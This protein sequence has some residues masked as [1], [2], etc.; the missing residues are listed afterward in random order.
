MFVFASF[1]E[2]LLTRGMLQRY[3]NAEKTSSNRIF[4]GYTFTNTPKT[5]SFRFRRFLVFSVQPLW[6]MMFPFLFF[7][8]IKC[9]YWLAQTL[10]CCFF[11]LTNM[12]VV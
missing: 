11:V 10:P 9:V 3:K 2:F 5:F 8:K 12:K 7:Y 4:A 1:A 6:I